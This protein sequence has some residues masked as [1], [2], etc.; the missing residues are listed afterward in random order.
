MILDP[1]RYGCNGWKY[2][3]LSVCNNNVMASGKLVEQLLLD[4]IQNDLF[5]EEGQA[6]FKEEAAKL[7]AEKRRMQKP[8][9]QQ[10]QKRMQ[11][12][13]R[14]IE[15]IMAAIKTG[16]LTP[17]TKQ[18]LEKA[19]AESARLLQATYAPKNNMEKVATFLPNAI[20]RLKAL[21]NDLANVTQLQV[22]KA[23]GSC[24]SCW[25]R[26]L[27]CTRLRTT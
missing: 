11:E 16:I 6:L 26:R 10:V 13:Q 5:T 2:R 27:S 15:N 14:E 3:G 24:G 12:V 4:A 17:S 19:E 22:D 8:N 25:G 21:L 9:Q 23:G 18:A 20:G 7:L 1:K